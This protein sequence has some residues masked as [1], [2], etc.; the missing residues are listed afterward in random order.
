MKRIKITTK[1]GKIIDGRDRLGYAIRHLADGEHAVQ[2][3]GWKEDRS[4]RQNALYWKWLS[5]I[6]NELGYHKDEL[7]EEFL[8]RFSYP[9]TYRTLDGK[10]KQRLLRSSAMNVEQMSAYMDRIFQFC[11]QELNI[12]LPIPE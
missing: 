1:E 4:L 3:S 2:F 10:P 7:H 8:E 5:I 11:L 6:G 12:N 9:I